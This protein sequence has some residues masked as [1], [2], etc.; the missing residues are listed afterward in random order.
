[1]SRIVIFVL[2]SSKLDAELSLF[3]LL[4]SNQ[5]DQMLEQKVAQNSPWAAKK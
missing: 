4:L 3:G 2:D 5:R 1:M